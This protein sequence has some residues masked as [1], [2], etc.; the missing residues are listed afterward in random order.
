MLTDPWFY[1]TAIPAVLLVGVSKSGFGAGFGALG[2]PLMALTMPVP[3]AAAV[4]LPL[5]AMMDAMGL[6]ALIRQRDDKLLK[7]LLPAGLVGTVIGAL[8]FKLLSARLVAGL[9]GGITL[10]FLAIRV[11]F[12]ARPDSKPPPRWLGAILATLSGFTSFVAHAGGPP[13]S[14]YVLPL[15]MDPIR[16]TATLAVFF[17]VINTAKWVPYAWLGLFDQEILL[18][19]LTLAPFTPIG[20][21]IGVRIVRKIKPELFYR[22]FV[23]GMMLTGT[24][25]LWDGLR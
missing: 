8:L 22:L 14:F 18:A 5:L 19:S 20:V 16:L 7:L 4:M 21:W 1:A 17:A 9:L 25:L 10:G 13:I 6:A 3:K 15:K 2:V 12:P 24:K 11:F 23:V